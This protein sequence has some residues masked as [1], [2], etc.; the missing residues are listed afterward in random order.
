LQRILFVVKAR[1]FGGLE[2]VLLDWLS[3]IDFSKASI[4]VC[5]YGTD[6][7]RQ[8]LAALAPQVESVSLTISDDAAFWSA[9]PGW[10]RLLSSTRADKI[11]FL[12]AM[13][14]DFG[15]TPIFAAWRLNRAHVYLFEA[16]WG[17]A[18]PADSLKKKLHFG[19]HPGIGWH[20]HKETLKQKL[21]AKFA[22]HT[23]VVSQEI[24]DNLVESYGYP[25]AQTSV[26]YHGVNVSRYRPSLPDG[27][28]FRRE[29]S[30]AETATVIVS[31]GRIVPRKRIDRLLKAFEPLYTE[32]PNLLLL[33]TSYGPFKD[34][35]EK[36]VA[37]SPASKGVK[38]V[39]FQEDPTRILKA[40]DIYALSSNDEGFGIALVEAL[41]T[42][43]VCVA[44]KGPGPKDII[45]DGQNGFL[46]EPSEE[47]VRGGLRRALNL[48]PQERAQLVERARQTAEVRFEIDAAIR[49]ALEAIEIPRK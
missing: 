15:V 35:I 26:L 3:Q 30:I 29:N 14:G 24:K 10:T 27:L 25:A 6:T 16:N 49:T 2:T 17:R 5:S 8:K 38:L 44:T 39:G 20:R 32:F 21:R 42:G 22:Y 33:L 48:T 34:E 4:A 12:E 18:T 28:A 1:E 43:L 9:L 40:S 19:F 11:V 23:F 31:H 46:V 37:N 47:G 13:V 7:L 45:S 36:A 41:S